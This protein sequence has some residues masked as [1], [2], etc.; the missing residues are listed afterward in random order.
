MDQVAFVRAGNAESAV[1]EFDRPRQLN[2]A[3][4]NPEGTIK[5]DWLGR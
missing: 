2:R 4:D 3:I 5:L 1:K